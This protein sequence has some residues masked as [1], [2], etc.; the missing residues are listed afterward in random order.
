MGWWYWSHCASSPSLSV[1]RCFY[2]KKRIHKFQDT[3]YRTTL[4]VIKSHSHW[5][6]TCYNEK[7]HFW[8]RFSTCSQSQLQT[9]CPP[10]CWDHSGGDWFT[11]SYNVIQGAVSHSAS[12]NFFNRIWELT[13]TFLWSHTQE[14]HP[15]K[16]KKNKFKIWSQK[17]TS[18]SFQ[19][20]NMLEQI[21]SYLFKSWHRNVSFVVT[22]L[23]AC[24]GFFVVVDVLFVLFTKAVFLCVA[25][26]I[27]ELTL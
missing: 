26:A 4:L 27:S 16:K 3:V 23:F 5:K 21:Y 11:A 10:T 24:L 9:H 12:E 8:D 19:S 6:V 2:K 18:P 13:R 7:K 17:L 15:T 25:L 22:F 1:M 20:S 14:G